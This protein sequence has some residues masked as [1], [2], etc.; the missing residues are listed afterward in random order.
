MTT[1][2]RFGKLFVILFALISVDANSGLFDFVDDFSTSAKDILNNKGIK[3]YIIPLDQGRLI[4]KQNFDKLDIGLSKEQV[5]YLLG[6]PSV[7]SPFKDSQWNYVYFNNSDQ[8]ELKNITIIYKNEKVF[9]I[10]INRKIYKKL[11]V[12]NITHQVKENAP[13]KKVLDET[14]IREMKPIQRIII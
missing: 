4:D 6:T 14:K 1:I 10:L 11:G 12:E 2:K 7:S 13:V 3:P 5:L 9:E 8:K